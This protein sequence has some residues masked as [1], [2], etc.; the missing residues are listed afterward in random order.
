[1]R[2]PSCVR[3]VVVPKYDCVSFTHTGVLRY[4]PN[5]SGRQLSLY[6]SI[7]PW[8]VTC[9]Y[10]VRWCVVCRVSG[11]TRVYV[12]VGM[13]VWYVCCVYVVCVLCVVTHVFMCRCMVY[14]YVRVCYLLVTEFSR[15]IR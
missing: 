8:C 3:V 1:M 4:E 13:Y 15:S 7:R 6:M 9:V 5:L 14:V 10:G 12:R 2:C 11:Y